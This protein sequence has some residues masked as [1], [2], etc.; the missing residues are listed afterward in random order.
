M[1]ILIIEDEK[2]L[3]ED[4]VDYL[5]ENGYKCDF[6]TT[7]KSA[8]QKLSDLVY[9]CALV[10]I[11][12]PDGSGMEVV[13]YIKKNSPEMG[14]IMITAKNALEDKLEGLKIGADDYLTKPFHLSELNARLYSVLRRRNYGGKNTLSFE[15]LEID[16]TEK[17]VIA[18]GIQL[19]LTKKEYEILVFLASSPTHLITKE[20]LADSIWGDKAEMAS[21]FDFVYSQIKNLK[22]KLNEAGITNYIKVV[23]GMGYKF[24]D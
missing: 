17:K 22:K 24:K 3:R 12:L 2:S 11:C 21:S 18:N 20:A 15:G 1:R 10:Y 16:T 23:Y 8:T 5:S 13:D 9:S 4:V 19:Q 7:V 14:V 6:A